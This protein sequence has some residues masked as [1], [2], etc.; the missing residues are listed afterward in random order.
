ML[1][2]KIF[3]SQSNFFLYSFV[4]VFSVTA[5]KGFLCKT[6]KKVFL[7]ANLVASTDILDIVFFDTQIRFSQRISSFLKGSIFYLNTKRKIGHSNSR[8]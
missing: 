7:N 6:R 3:G 1:L 5:Y 2:L 4:V 8:Q